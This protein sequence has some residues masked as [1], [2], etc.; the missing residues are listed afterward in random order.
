MPSPRG[1]VYL[2]H[3]ERPYKH[4]R[5]YLGFAEDLQRR[6]E[7]HHAGRG[8]RLVQVVVAA[9][10]G[11][12]LVRTGRAT[13]R[14]SGHSRTATTRRRAYVP[15]A[16]PRGAAMADQS[17]RRR[18]TRF[19]L[20]LRVYARTPLCRW[21]RPRPVEDPCVKPPGRWKAA[22]GV[23]ASGPARPS[24]WGRLAHMP[25]LALVT[26]AAGRVDRRSSGRTGAGP[27]PG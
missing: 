13:G 26:P 25:E 15:C 27:A 22:T 8:A 16:G 20:H 24:G 3:F 7:L 6:L 23:A 21:N 12:Q 1:T 19:P 14:S 5:H 2:L 18:S 9:G 17:S 11:F 10:I 4:A